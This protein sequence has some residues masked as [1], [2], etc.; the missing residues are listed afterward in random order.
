M[1]VFFISPIKNKRGEIHLAL[2]LQLF[3]IGAG[4]KADLFFEGPTEV[5]G[6]GI[7]QHQGD[8]LQSGALLQK[9]AGVVCSFFVQIGAGGH[10]VGFFK[11]L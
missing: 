6:C 11:D 7:A 3:F 4:G 2:L 1:F 10:P 8:L 5:K 9:A